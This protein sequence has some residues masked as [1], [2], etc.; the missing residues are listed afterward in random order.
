MESKGAA[1]LV[2]DR[3]GAFV[4]RSTYKSQHETD[5][6]ICCTNGNRLGIALVAARHAKVQVFLM[7]TSEQAL[8]KGL[9]FMGKY[10]DCHRHC[11]A[12]SRGEV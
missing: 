9:A 7:D 1:L 11:C 6:R 8:Q 12:L 10:F 4:N 5:Y 3:W 2:P